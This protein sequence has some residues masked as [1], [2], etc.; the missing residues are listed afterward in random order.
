MIIGAA[1]PLWFFINHFNEQGFGLSLF[2]QLAFA[3][4]VST[5][6][7]ADLLISSFIFWVILGIDANRLGAGRIAMLIAA[8]CLIGLSLAL[9]WYLYIRESRAEG[10]HGLA[11]EGGV[12]SARQAT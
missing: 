11:L 6:A 3:N 8:N 10:R 9:P 2:L 5:G 1:A 12:N 4:K 7:V